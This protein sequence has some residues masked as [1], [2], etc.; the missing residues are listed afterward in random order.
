ME[1]KTMPADG[2]IT[3]TGI[4]DGRVVAAFSQDFTVGGGALG[5]IHSKKICEHD[6]LRPQD[7]LPHGR[8]Q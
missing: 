1:D 4:V 7:R 6:G 3:G 5:R 8:F 2:V